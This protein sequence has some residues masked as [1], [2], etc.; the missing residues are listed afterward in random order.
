MVTTILTETTSNTAAANMLVPVA[1]SVA[2]AAGVSPIQ[3]AIAVCLAASLAFMLPVSTPPNAVVYG[4][5][6]VPLTKM[7]RHGLVLDVV[8]MVA[9]VVTVYWLVPLVIRY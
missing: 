4:S 5:G 7:I 1:I 3:P 8:S 6:C 9:V 2:L